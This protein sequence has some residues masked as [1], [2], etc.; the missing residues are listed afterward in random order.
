SAASRAERA[1]VVMAA[2]WRRTP[3]GTDPNDGPDRRLEAGPGHHSR[4]AEIPAAYGVPTSC[5]G[6]KPLGPRTDCQD[7]AIQVLEPGALLLAHVRDAI[8]GLQP[9][10]VVLLERDATVPQLL[11]RRRQVVDLEGHARRLVRPGELGR[12]DE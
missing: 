12:V 8:H 6:L 3:T 4:A 1:G 2:F 11:D 7:V 5:R 10:E 9:G